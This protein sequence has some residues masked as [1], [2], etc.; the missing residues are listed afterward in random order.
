VRRAG[1]FPR[2]SCFDCHFRKFLLRFPTIGM[3]LFKKKAA[4]RSATPVTSYFSALAQA[5]SQ[6]HNLNGALPTA[7]PALSLSSSV[8]SSSEDTILHEEDMEI[9]NSDGL[10]LPA[11][12]PN[13]SEVFSTIHTE[14]GHCSNSDYRYVSRWTGSPISA[15][16]DQDPPYYVLLS[17]YISYLILICIGH[18]RDFVG[19][20]LRP[21]S[22][23]HLMPNDVRRSTTICFHRL[24]IL[25]Y[26]DTRR[27]TP[28]LIRSIPAG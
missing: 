26:R 14:F 10:A 5:D 11:R 7:T 23:R 16:V 25:H 21:A 19:K 18:L 27:S 24:T 28:T 1:I 15:D 17:T 6:G 12:A 20:R 9:D 8:T 22:Y 13:S 2:L 4:S 3:S